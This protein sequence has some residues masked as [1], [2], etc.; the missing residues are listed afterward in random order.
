MTFDGT[1]WSFTGN[2]LATGEVTAYSDARLKSDIRTIERGGRLRP[3]SFIKDGSRHVGLI[4]QEVQMLCPDVVS[5]GN[6]PDH[7]L[8]LNYSGALCYGFA[9]VY[10][11]LDRHETRIRELERN[12]QHLK[13]ENE[14]LKQKINYLERR[15]VA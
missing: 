15:L 4:A 8:S 14:S 9:G 10:N 5:V 2:I 6:D 13:S 7:L 12:N 11:E 3:V 1:T